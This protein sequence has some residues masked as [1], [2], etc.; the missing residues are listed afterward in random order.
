MLPYI[1]YIPSR[2]IFIII[3]YN[4]W[5]NIF[6]PVAYRLCEDTVCPSYHWTL[7]TL[8]LCVPGFAKQVFDK[9]LLPSGSLSDSLRGWSLSLH[10]HFLF[11]IWFNYFKPIWFYFHPGHISLSLK[12]YLIAAIKALLPSALFMKLGVR[13]MAST[14]IT[15]ADMVPPTSKGSHSWFHV[16]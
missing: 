8:L 7:N 16:K 1:P 11:K 10:V 4:C 5:S 3:F 14:W 12:K 13:F 15:F 2:I 6:S 9:Y